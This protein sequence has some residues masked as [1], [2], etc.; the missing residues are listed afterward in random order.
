L[1]KLTTI[2]GISADITDMTIR[3]KHHRINKLLSK[4]PMFANH[5]LVGD[6]S[7]SVPVWYIH[8]EVGS[9]I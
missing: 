9:A 2:N 5:Y 7:L 6:G 8:D 3:K 4:L 1:Q